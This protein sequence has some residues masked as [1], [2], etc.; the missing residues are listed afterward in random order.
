MTIGDTWVY[1]VR[2]DD[3][4]RDTEPDTLETASPQHDPD[5]PVIY[6]G[7]LKSP[8]ESRFP[9]DDFS[10]SRS[11]VVKRYGRQLLDEFRSKHNN[12]E[13]ALSQHERHLL[14]LRGRGWA[15]LTPPIRRRFNVYVIEL[16]TDVL[17]ERPGLRKANPDPDPDLP[18]VYVGKTHHDPA[19]RFRIH[20]EGGS[21]SSGYVEKFGVHLRP[22]LYAC[23]NPCTELEAFRKGRRLTRVLRNC[24]FTVAGGH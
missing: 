19:K 10:S 8:P 16:K 24:G 7:W 15:V 13:G 3:S 14:T 20:K 1:A 12:K 11:R 18:P 23:Y 4:I 2:L 21:R 9:D 6:L 17:E 22:D 5:T